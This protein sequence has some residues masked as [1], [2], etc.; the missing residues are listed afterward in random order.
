MSTRLNWDTPLGAMRVHDVADYAALF[1]T[2]TGEN[3]ALVLTKEEF[4]AR[5]V[6]AY[7]KFG[8]IEFVNEDRD[9]N[10][11]VGD[12]LIPMKTILLS[13]T[14]VGCI[15][16]PRVPA[17]TPRRRGA[18]GLFLWFNCPKCED[19]GLPLDFS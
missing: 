8:P 10:L 5:A 18:T 12:I 16:L 15:H 9:G 14:K 19:L 7:D 2:F 6:E 17:N 4:I 1:H 3:I 13:M 11:L